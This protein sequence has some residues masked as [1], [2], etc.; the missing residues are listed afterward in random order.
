MIDSKGTTSF[1]PTGRQKC[2]DIVLKVFVLT[3]HTVLGRRRLKLSSK[4]FLLSKVA[5][6]LSKR[7]A[8]KLRTTEQMLGKQHAEASSRQS[9]ERE[10][11]HH[12]RQEG[13]TAVKVKA[14]LIPEVT[15]TSPEA[16][17]QCSGAGSCEG[18][19]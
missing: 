9:M 14:D 7:P 19:R 2:D 6:V 5:A 16:P 12:K 10:G 13:A 18:E 11:G 17:R 1:R 15:I 4:Y 8:Q 3:I